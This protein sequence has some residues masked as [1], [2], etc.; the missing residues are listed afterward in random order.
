MK[1]STKLTKWSK[2]VRE[3]DGNECK[4]C[5]CKEKLHAHH[6]IPKD[7]DYSL[8]YDI[9]NGIT[10]C[11]SCHAKTEGYQKGHTH[12]KEVRKKLSES[13]KKSYAEGKWK[14]W[15][16]GLKMSEEHRKKL[17]D[18]HIGQVAWNKG[19]K[20]DKPSPKKGIKVPEH[21]RQALIEA[22]RK[23]WE[24]RKLEGLPG[25][26]KGIKTSEEDKKKI[27]EALKKAYA[28][29]RRIK[30]PMSEETKRKIAETKN[31]K[32]VIII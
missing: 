8:R 29:G 3:R 4:L 32:K 23:T 12:P 7:K 28:E 30:K 16:E 27:S 21:V 1:D 18:A 20:S 26:R 5:K 14:V 13:L 15:S 17:S 11:I 22:N 19:L 31:R 2:Q 24:K 6:I 25:P 10:L 9:N